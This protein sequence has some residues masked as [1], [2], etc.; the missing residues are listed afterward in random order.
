MLLPRRNRTN[1]ATDLLGQQLLPYASLPSK[2]PMP[3]RSEAGVGEIPGGEAG[4]I[5]VAA[6]HQ[7]AGRAPPLGRA[8]Q[9][10]FGGFSEVVDETCVADD[11]D[12]AEAASPSPGDAD[13]AARGRAPGAPSMQLDLAVGQDLLRAAGIDPYRVVLRQECRQYNALLEAIRRSLGRLLE[14][15]DGMTNLDPEIEAVH[16]ALGRN[17]VP[18]AWAGVGF[19]SNKAL[20]AWF[21][22]L[23]E[24][25]AFFAAWAAAPG[26]T[27]PS[28]FRL[29]AFCFP[30]A[31]LS[32]VLQ[33]RC[34]TNG[35]DTS[36]RK[37][38]VDSF[39]VLRRPTRAATRCRW[40][41]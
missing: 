7:A 11:D 29:S 25:V 1:S 23:V 12:D 19:S 30:Q 9:G 22:E 34:A 14:A 16:A 2:V 32:A 26:A 18:G 38:R 36:A 20:S 31:L 35:T 39:T 37:R 28:A 27:P 21:A 6:A 5:S 4:V 3:Q 33:V 13:A 40:T 8:P 17:A 10:S 41:S 24:N 15:I